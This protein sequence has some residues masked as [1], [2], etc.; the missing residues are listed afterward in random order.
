LFGDL[1]SIFTSD[2]LPGGNFTLGNGGF[3]SNIG[4]AG[5]DTSG[6]FSQSAPSGELSIAKMFLEL[7]GAQ[8]E[9]KQSTQKLGESTTTAADSILKMATAASKGGGALDLLP[10]LIRGLFSGGSPGM[11]ILGGITSLFGFDEGGYTGA[12]GKHQPAGVVHKGEVVWSQEDVSKAGGPAVVDAMRRGLRG[13]AEGGIVART[14]GM[15][16]PQSTSTGARA[17]GMSVTNN[18][19]IQGPVDRRTEEQIAAAAFRGASRANR[20]V[21]A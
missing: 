7:G 15:A 5:F 8:A 17:S 10:E 4:N 6:F 21:T 3:G 2:P 11:S 20:R 14:A 19:T 1:G 9:T 16:P 18:F 12:G 13:Y